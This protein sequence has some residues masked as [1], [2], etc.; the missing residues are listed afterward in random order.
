MNTESRHCLFDTNA[1]VSH[2][3]SLYYS[4]WY[5]ILLLLI[6]FVSWVTHQPLVG[7]Y[8]LIFLCV[9]SLIIV[10]D[11]TPSLYIIPLMLM[12]TSTEDFLAHSANFNAII[13][14]A[15]LFSVALV[16]HIVIYRQH[17]RSGRLTK[18]LIFVC[19]AMFLGGIGSPYIKQYFDNIL[20]VLSLAPL[21]LALYIIARSCVELPRDVDAKIYFARIISMFAVF[22]A[23]QVLVLRLRIEGDFLENLRAPL[24]SGWANRNGLATILLIGIG[25]MF[26]Y[27][28]NAKR[29]NFLL[30]HLAFALDLSLVFTYSRGGGLAGLIQF[31]AIVIIMLV[32]GKHKVQFLIAGGMWT[33]GIGAAFIVFREYLPE[34]IKRLH[35]VGMGSNGR[36]RLFREAWELFKQYPIF[37]VGFGYYNEGGLVHYPNTIYWIHNTVLQVMSFMGIVGVAIYI[38]YYIERIK[39]WLHHVNVFKLFGMCSIIAFEGQSLVDTGTFSSI[40]FLYLAVLLEIFVEISSDIDDRN[41]QDKFMLEVGIDVDMF[42]ARYFAK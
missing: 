15:V 36:S 18:P 24:Q 39:M 22:A 16:S 30:F 11:I 13:V 34:L 2:V 38:Y 7:I 3:R 19:I 4:S 21:M 26:Y 5:P 14:A 28:D 42:N 8:I 40:P 27:A 12:T 9:I 31:V 35:E 32:K 29:G 37:G 17:Y 33:V 25:T 23:L 6:S 1:L 10:R 20:F 41:R